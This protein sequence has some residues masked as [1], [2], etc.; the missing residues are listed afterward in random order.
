MVDTRIIFD[1]MRSTSEIL[2]VKTGAQLRFVQD[3]QCPFALTGPRITSQWPH[4]SAGFVAL[5]YEQPLHACFASAAESVYSSDS[6]MPR[7]L[8]LNS[9]GSTQAA[10]AEPATNSAAGAHI[11]QA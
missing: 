1:F 2:V 5:K 8:S 10:T 7:T 3:T 4:A 11:P 6:R 9:S